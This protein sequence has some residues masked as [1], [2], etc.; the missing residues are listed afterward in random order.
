MGS[1]DV[2]HVG[3]WPK[4]QVGHEAGRTF[5]QAEMRAATEAVKAMISVVKYGRVMFNWG[6]A[7]RPLSGPK[8]CT[9]SLPRKFFYQTCSSNVKRENIRNHAFLTDIVD[10]REDAKRGPH[11]TMAL[12]RPCDSRASK[13]AN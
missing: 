2:R 3:N 11:S 10:V 9:V 6:C 1:S 7:T 4:S 12:D 13:D 5:T 8:K